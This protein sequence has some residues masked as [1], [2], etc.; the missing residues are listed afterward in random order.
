MRHAKMGGGRGLNVAEI[1]I[2]E[3]KPYENNPRRISDDA[4]NAVAESIR[5]FGFKVPLIVD[6]DNVIICGHTRL[7]AAQKLGLETVPCIRADDLTP[8]QVKAFRLADNKTA[9]LTAWDFSALEAELDALS[10]IDMSLFGF[11][12]GAAN[13]SDFDGL[14]TDTPRT[15]E[16]EKKKIR[17]PHCGEWFEP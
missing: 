16:A 3:L 7:Q 14:F 2:N 5:N 13:L 4:V 11:D 1:A 9:E 10:E 15:E 17:C 6:G 8:E 12:D